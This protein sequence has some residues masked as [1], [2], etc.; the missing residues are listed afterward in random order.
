MIFCH[1][2]AKPPPCR[3]FPPLTTIG[4]Q[5]GCRHVD[6]IISTFSFLSFCLIICNE[7]SVLLILFVCLCPFVL[8]CSLVSTSGLCLLTN[9]CYGKYSLL[10]AWNGSFSS[11][12]MNAHL[13]PH[14]Q[15]IIALGFWILSNV[16]WQY[17]LRKNLCKQHLLSN[18]L[19]S[20]LIAP[21]YWKWKACG[22]EE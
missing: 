1:I 4:T 22:I 14:Y 11:L 10:A 17:G 16:W 3:H 7:I 12:S 5:H 9:S 15:N 6:T 2:G 19:V 13:V 18:K 21:V 20:F 8:L